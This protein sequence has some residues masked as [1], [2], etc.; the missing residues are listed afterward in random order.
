MLL[1]VGLHFLGTSTAANADGRFGGLGSLDRLSADRALAVFSSSKFLKTSENVSIEL[2]LAL[3][4]AESDLDFGS[5]AA[6]VD[7]LAFDRAGGVDGIGGKGAGEAQ[8]KAAG[9][10]GK[11]FFHIV[12][13]VGQLTN[14]I[15][16]LRCQA[17]RSK[18]IHRGSQTGE[19]AMRSS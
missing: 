1:R 15:K 4:A 11:E 18:S 16:P 12:F 6:G 10:D 7:F 3:A 5:L 2:V 13:L 9:E 17:T 14:A 19:S 8:E